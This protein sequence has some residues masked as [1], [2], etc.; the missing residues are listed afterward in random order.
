MIIY[1]RLTW[2][3]HIT[4]VRKSFSSKFYL[5][6]RISFLP[7]AT[8]EEIYFKTIVPSVV[9]GIL[10]WGS[11][12]HSGLQPLEDLHARAARII[13]RLPKEIPVE[14]RIIKTRW[15]PLSYPHKRRLR[16]FIFEVYNNLTDERLIKL[17][18]KCRNKQSEYKQNFDLIRPKK[19]LTRTSIRYRGPIVWNNLPKSLKALQGNKETFKRQL[20]KHTK[21]LS[22]ITFSKETINNYNKKRL[23]LLL[24]LLLFSFASFF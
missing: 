24:I 18:N 1:N 11:C 21:H 19:E 10:V 6:R 9:Y 2:T 16:I 4:S 15:K 5:L 13:H 12:S 17:F 22:N 14:E 8:Q 7:I 3:R 20:K 23:L